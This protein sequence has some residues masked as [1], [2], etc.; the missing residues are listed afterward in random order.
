MICRVIATA[1]GVEEGLEPNAKI[2]DATEMTP[3][4]A[5][6][7]VVKSEGSARGVIYAPGTWAWAQL[8][9]EAL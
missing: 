3:T 8:E 7:L 2:P 9:A 1:E 4:S 6:A 5:G